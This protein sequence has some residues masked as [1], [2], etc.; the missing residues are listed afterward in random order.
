MS[1]RTAEFFPTGST[2]PLTT[3]DRAEETETRTFPFSFFKFLHTEN[4]V[5]QIFL[6]GLWVSDPLWHHGYDPVSAGQT[7][8]CQN[9][10][11]PGS[12]MINTGM[13][14]S[15]A[16]V[17]TK[18]GSNPCEN[19]VPLSRSVSGGH[20]GPRMSEELCE[21]GNFS[22]APDEPPQGSS[23]TRGT[24]EKR[25]HREQQSHLRLLPLKDKSVHFYL[26]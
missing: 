14:A 22:Q 7:D 26:T 24:T 6:E 9:P 19:S 5:C 3:S 16:A 23:S 12:H 25:N 21:D 15:S 10:P 8:L 11:S 20:F 17:P 18:P 2:G 13:L 1:V 4:K